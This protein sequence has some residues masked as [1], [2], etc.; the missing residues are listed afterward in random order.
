M[1]DILRDL[2]YCS[3]YLVLIAI[4]IGMIALVAACVYYCIRE[5]KYRTKNANK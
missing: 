3:L 2:A 4:A 5:V 1:L